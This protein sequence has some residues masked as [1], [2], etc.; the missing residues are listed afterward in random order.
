MKKLLT[1]LGVLFVGAIFTSFS[2]VEGYYPGVRLYYDFDHDYYHCRTSFP[3]SEYKYNI[4]LG[5][6]YRT[7]TYGKETATNDRNEHVH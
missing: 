4:M 7:W 1:V 6:N 5:D 2:D 3:Q